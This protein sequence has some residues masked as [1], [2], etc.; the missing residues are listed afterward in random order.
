MSDDEY[1][2]FELPE[3]EPV[4][5]V[6]EGV[7]IKDGN[8]VKV[9]YDENELV[10]MQGAHTVFAFREDEPGTVSMLRSGSITTTLIFD[11]VNTRQL[12]LYS[13]GAIPFEVAVCTDH[14]SNTVTYKSGGEINAEY[15][16]EIRGIPAE[17][18]RISVKVSEL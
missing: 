18:N 3:E 1:D 16:V 13:A 2:E 7:I 17:Y 6:S 5:F 11:S 12:C 4:V 10:G 14:L 8:M 9:S 15:T